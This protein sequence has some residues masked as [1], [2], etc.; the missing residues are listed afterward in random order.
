[1]SVGDMRKSLEHLQ[2]AV[3]LAP[4]NSTNHLFLAQTLYRLH[5]RSLAEGQLEIVLRC[6][7]QAISPQNLED[8]RKEARRLLVD[9]RGD[10]IEQHPQQPLPPKRK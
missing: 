7:Q 5:Y 6:T 1:M 10:K 9:L 8:D 4:E 3:R 2:A